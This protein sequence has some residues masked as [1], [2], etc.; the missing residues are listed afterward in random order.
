[1]A[2]FVCRFRAIKEPGRNEVLKILKKTFT[3]NNIDCVQLILSIHSMK[4]LFILATCLVA[5]AFSGLQSGAMAQDMEEKAIPAPV[6]TAFKSRFPNAAESKWKKTKTGK[7][8]AKFKQAGQK[9]EAKFMSDGKWD[10][11]EITK[12][13]NDLPATAAEYLK[14][15]YANQ[16]IDKVEWKEEAAGKQEY[17]VKLKKDNNGKQTE[18]TFDGAGKFIKEKKK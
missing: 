1:M 17:E 9:A 8:E 4:K 2:R 5:L 6:M 13:P 15:N 14:K 11:A 3:C 10:S 18:L 7:Y 12:T 16:A